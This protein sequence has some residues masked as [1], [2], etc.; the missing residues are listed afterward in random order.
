ML[1]KRGH[2]GTDRQPWGEDG[3]KMHRETTASMSEGA[4]PLESLQRGHSPADASLLDSGPQNGET[5]ATQSVV[6]GCSSPEQPSTVVSATGHQL[7]STV[8]QNLPAKACLP[9]L[10][11]VAGVI[12]GPPTHPLPLGPA[13][14]LPESRQWLPASFGQEHSL[15]TGAGTRIPHGLGECPEQP[16]VTERQ[17]L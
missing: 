10:L 2:L 5:M 7:E 11:C 6:F 15:A 13:E 16:A 14:R 8:T 17:Q 4:D 1:T 9:P 12:H 3:L